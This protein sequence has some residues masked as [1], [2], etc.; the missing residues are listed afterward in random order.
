MQLGK[1][2]LQILQAVIDDYICSGEPVGSR[3][4]AKKYGMGISPATIRN[5]MSDLEEMGYL[6]QPHTSAGR[7]PSDKAYRLYVDKLMKIRML[8]AVEAEHIKKIYEQKTTEI[9]KIIE[10]VAKVLSDITNYTSVVLGPQLNKILIKRIQ[11]IPV[12][13][14]YTLLVVVTSAGIIKDTII[15]VPADIDPGYLD[16]VSNMLTEHYRD[17]TFAEVDIN[18]IQDVQKEMSKQREFF[19]SLIDALTESIAQKEQTEVYLGGTTN[20][21]N[22]P[23]YRDIMK[24][25]T[26]LSFMEQK[27][28]LYNL[29]SKYDKQ[30]VRVI[31]GTENEYEQMKEC[32]IVMAT[33]SIGDKVLGTLGLI[34]PTRMEYSKAVSVVRYVGETVSKYLTSLFEE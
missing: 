28:L 30:G 20:I 16:R 26:F 24:A 9:E 21:F 19:N 3:T 14:Q 8:T 2:K 22:F 6:H 11:L 23:E 25:R 4:I 18:S 13:G 7:I 33:Y 32:S 29:L 27:N 1:R 31:I 12:E 15:R 5:E 34:G 17:K 10:Q